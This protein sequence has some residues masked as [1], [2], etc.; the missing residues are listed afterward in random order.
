MRECAP[1]GEIGA[2][3]VDGD[4]LFA[5]QVALG[6]IQADG[7]WTTLAPAEEDDDP[8]VF[9]LDAADVDEG[10]VIKLFDACCATYDALAA[11][12]VRWTQRGTYRPKTSAEQSAHHSVVGGRY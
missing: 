11:A 6:D 12:T 7:Q 2:E 8:N 5:A 9:R 3:A 4:A 1:L 10:D